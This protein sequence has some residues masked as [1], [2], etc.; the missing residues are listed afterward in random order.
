M[1]KMLLAGVAAASLAVVSLASVP[2][3]AGEVSSNAIATAYKELRE[4]DRQIR[5][6]DE[7]ESQEEQRRD[8]QRRSRRAFNASAL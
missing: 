3:V 1:R 7:A 5:V 8:E 4:L 6:I 2:V